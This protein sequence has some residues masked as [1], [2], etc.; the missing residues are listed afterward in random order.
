MPHSRRPFLGVDTSSLRARLSGHADAA[1]AR[2][3]ADP[4]GECAR[5]PSGREPRARRF[6]RGGARARERRAQSGGRAGRAGPIAGGGNRAARWSSSCAPGR[7]TRREEI[8]VVIRHHGA[9]MAIAKVRATQIRHALLLGSPDSEEDTPPGVRSRRRGDGTV[10]V[11]GAQSRTRTVRLP[12]A[13]PLPHPRC[14]R[15]IRLPAD[16]RAPRRVA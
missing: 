10:C 7:S 3:T 4:R 5:A 11:R 9:E 15:Q 13:P 8:P 2:A 6:T 1:R 12:R 14:G 16:D